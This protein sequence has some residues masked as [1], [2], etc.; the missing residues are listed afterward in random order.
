M[1]LKLAWATYPDPL[2]KMDKE[3]VRKRDRRREAEG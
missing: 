2:S 1:S 3:R